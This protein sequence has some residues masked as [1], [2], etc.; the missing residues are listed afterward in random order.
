[1]LSS[2]L[3]VNCLLPQAFAPLQKTCASGSDGYKIPLSFTRSHLLWIH[4]GVTLLSINCCGQHSVVTGTSSAFRV[5]RPPPYTPAAYPLLGALLRY[6]RARRHENS[7]STKLSLLP[8]PIFRT[9]CHPKSTYPWPIL[10]IL[11]HVSSTESNDPWAHATG[12]RTLS[13]SRNGNRIRS[14]SQ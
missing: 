12:I 6:E 2:S 9:S 1:M 14:S 10:W 3:G 11:Q 7:G 4:D 13:S 8:H 5:P